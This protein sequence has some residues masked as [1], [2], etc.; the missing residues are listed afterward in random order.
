MSISIGYISS[1]S[2]Q[3]LQ[4]LEFEK[5]QEEILAGAIEAVAEVEQDCLLSKT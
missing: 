1:F 5:N 4:I 3:V 2:H